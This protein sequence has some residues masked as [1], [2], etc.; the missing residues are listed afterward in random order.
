MDEL[1]LLENFIF[2]HVNT[3]VWYAHK[4]ADRYHGNYLG[5]IGFFLNYSFLNGWAVEVFHSP[6][7]L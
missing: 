3:F 7:G 4:S 1:F 2:N 5:E 6:V